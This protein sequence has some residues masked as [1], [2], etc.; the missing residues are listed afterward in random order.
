[1][2]C[3]WFVYRGD[4]NY[5]LTGVFIIHQ[6]TTVDSSHFHVLSHKDVVPAVAKTDRPLGPGN[7]LKD[8]DVG[9]RNAAICDCE[10]LGGKSSEDNFPNG[11]IVHGDESHG[12]KHELMVLQQK[13]LF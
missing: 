1:M 3:S 8:M 7:R 5:L 4:P 13:Y 12:R 6:E 2:P 10:P 9:C 11:G